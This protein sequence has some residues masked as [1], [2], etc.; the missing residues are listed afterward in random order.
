MKQQQ[1][2]C[3]LQF[4]LLRNRFN[5]VIGSNILNSHVLR[6]PESCFQASQVS[7]NNPNN[8]L[9]VITEVKKL[10]NNSPRILWIA[11]FVPEGPSEVNPVPLV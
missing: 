1:P 10:L 8:L 7:G 9:D 5:E 3:S 2:L 6:L 4:A 11:R